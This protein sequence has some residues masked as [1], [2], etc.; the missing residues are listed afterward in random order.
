MKVSVVMPVYNGGERMRRTIESVLAQTW[1]DFDFVCIDDGSTDG[2]SAAILDEYAAKDP[3]MTVVHQRNQGPCGANN[4]G[5]RMCTGEFVVR[6][7]QDDVMHP[8]ELEYCARA[9][10]RYGLDFLAFRYGRMS[11]DGS[12]PRFGDILSGIDRLFVC[13]AVSKTGNPEEYRNSLSRVHIDS[14]AQFIRR[15]LALSVPIDVEW[16]LTRPFKLIRQ[17]RRW[18][19]SCD[20]LYFYDHGV[21]TSMMHQVFT[22]QDL[23]W[24]NEDMR[25][26]FSLYEDVRDAGDP[27]GE[28][29]TLCRSYVVK[30]IKSQLNKI[31]RQRS[32][33]PRIVTD[34]LFAEL[35]ETV[36]EFFFCRG[37][38]FGYA[39]L[40]H[41]IWYIWLM[42]R[43]RSRNRRRGGKNGAP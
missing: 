11:V 42:L 13:D 12:M 16:G 8:Q 39:S 22:M 3:R 32:R 36:R 2:V 26:L 37:V 28:W 41:Q 20:V 25:N 24:D 5:I 4:D 1:S 27:F 23:L 34:M 6:C 31:R 7:D 40:R 19:A 14:W 21:E 15:D 17:S 33:I 9:V 29:E 35:V 10:Q 30:R 43:Y 38:P 18:A